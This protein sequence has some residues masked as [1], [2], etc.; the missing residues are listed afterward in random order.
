VFRVAFRFR[1]SG[2]RDV[3]NDRCSNLQFGH[4]TVEVACHDAFAKRLEAMHLGLD[5]AS[6]KVT[7]PLPPDGPPKR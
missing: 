5:T 6:P 2:G 7:A 1:H 4:L 3:A